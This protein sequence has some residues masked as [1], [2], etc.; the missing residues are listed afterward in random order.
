MIKASKTKIQQ[1]AVGYGFISLWIIGFLVFS[2]Y[3]IIYS[4]I[5]SL[6][7]VVIGPDGIQMTSIGLQNYS[8]L[9][10]LDVDFLSHL[11][12]YFKEVFISVPLVIILS[13]VIAKLL[14]SKIPGQTLFRT[15]FFLPVII[16]S[17]PVMDIFVKNLLFETLLDFESVTLLQAI[18]NSSYGILSDVVVFLVKNIAD[19]LW[20][21][22]VPIIIFITGF[23]K[24]PKDMYEAASIDGASGWQCFWKL[25]LPSLVGFIGI[26]VVFSV[27]QI[28]TIDSMPIIKTIGNKMFDTNYGFGY[29]A[30]IAWVYFIAMLMMI[31]VFGLLIMM[32]QRRKN[33]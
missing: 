19:I 26:N 15:L 24:L 22:G 9:F 21:A 12:D 23:Q 28:S 27:I 3:P 29:A 6:N 32:M 17:G 11:V 18:E 2:L 31:G 7:K 5:L 25:T 1:A 30:S 10:T 16:I 14:N 13:M 33:K 20:Y 8:K 4:I